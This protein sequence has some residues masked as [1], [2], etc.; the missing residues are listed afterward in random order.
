MERI[1][2][3]MEKQKLEMILREIDSLNE[4]TL[5]IS[6]VGNRQFMDEYK[7]I[8]ESIE[9]LIRIRNDEAYDNY[10][11]QGYIEI[12]GRLEEVI[13]AEE[14]NRRKYGS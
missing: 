10:D 2:K 6:Y 4:R 12:A 5:D 7:F 14:Y 11:I 9:D 8:H 3:I 1:S 13:Y